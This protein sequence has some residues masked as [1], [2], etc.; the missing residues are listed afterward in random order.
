MEVE[1]AKRSDKFVIYPEDIYLH[2]KYVLL[3]NIEV[4]GSIIETGLQTLSKPALLQQYP[5]G[6]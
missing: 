2:K 6:P 4:G 5:R 1:A 3:L